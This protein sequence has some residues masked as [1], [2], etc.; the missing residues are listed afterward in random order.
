M[1]IAAAP[2]PR[3]LNSRRVRTLHVPR[4]RDYQIPVLLAAA[5]YKVVAAGRRWGKSTT[6]LVACLLGHGPIDPKTGLPK[7]L[8][9]IHGA[10]IYWVVPDFP[11]SGHDRWRDLKK[12]TRGVRTSKSEMEHRVGLPGGGSITIKSADDPDSIRG[13]GLDGVVM[14]EA[15]LMAERVW[16]EV[17]RAALADRKGWAIF[18]STPKGKA[19]WFYKV[20][21]RGISDELLDA[22]KLDYDPRR[23]NWQSW[24]RPSTDNPQMDPEEVGEAALELGSL[25]FAQ[26][27]EAS[28]IVAGGLVIKRSWFR[29]YSVSSDGRTITLEGDSVRHV[30]VASLTRWATCDLAVSTKTSADYTVIGTFAS[31]PTGEL[32]LLDMAR[33]RMEG[34]DIVPALQS[35]WRRHRWS[36]VGVEGTAFQ[37]SIVQ[38]AARAGLPVTK[39]VADGDKHARAV[40]IAARCE[41]GMFLMPREAPWVGQ[42]EEELEG[43]PNAAHDDILDVCSYAAIEAADDKSRTLQTS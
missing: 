3:Q 21:L 39:L 23:A 10:N 13:P 5:R 19:N 43:F 14:D 30:A 26:E 22:Q 35:E 15:P 6:G 41:A 40:F 11:T 1:A 36:K 33:D 42:V 29:Y 25:V 34:P 20:W 9:A 38:Q 17:L 16:T 8:G 2:R 27:Y 31:L 37:L 18:L 32:L 28:F 12:A 24:Q 4:P 7:F